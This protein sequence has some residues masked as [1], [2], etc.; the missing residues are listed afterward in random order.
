MQRPHVYT[1]TS[2]LVL[3]VYVPLETMLAAGC[4]GVW[5]E[6]ELSVGVGVGVCAC[7]CLRVFYELGGVAYAKS[8][9]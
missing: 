9:W 6:C 1:C 3:Y 7:V 5:Y 8:V 4:L 2:A